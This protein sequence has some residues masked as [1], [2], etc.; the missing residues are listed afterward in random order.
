MHADQPGDQFAVCLVEPV[1]RA[2][3]QGIG[4]AEFG[5]VAP[6]SL[7]NVV[8]QR[9]QIEQFGFFEAC[10]QAAGKRQFVCVFRHAQAPNISQH[11]KDVLIH[12]VNVKQIVL[13][14]SDDTAKCRDVTPQQAVAMH[15]A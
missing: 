13:H 10:D 5:M 12:G 4:P 7:G 15:R 2:K 8:K 11:G 6:A 9:G 3:P 1:L 14:L